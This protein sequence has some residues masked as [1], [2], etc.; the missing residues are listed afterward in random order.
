MGMNKGAWS[1]VKASS[2]KFASNAGTPKTKTSRK[3]PAGGKR[4]K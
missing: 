4:K 2:G 3:N 1:K